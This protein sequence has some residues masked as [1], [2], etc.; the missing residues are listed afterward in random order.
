MRLDRCPQHASMA[1]AA[2]RCRRT[3]SAV[4]RPASTASRTR[5]CTNRYSPGPEV[6]STS[7][8]S[9]ASVQRGEALQ[10]RA[11]S[12][13][14]H[15]RHGELA[16]H[17]RRRPQQ[18]PRRRGSRPS[19]API[20]SRTLSVTGD[21]WPSAPVVASARRDL[22]DEERV[23]AGPGVHPLDDL[24][25]L[26]LPTDQ[27]RS[28]AGRHGRRGSPRISSATSRAPAADRRQDAGTRPVSRWLT[29]TSSRSTVIDR[30]TCWS[31]S[32]DACVGPLGV[33]EHDQQGTGQASP[34]AAAA[35]RRRT[36]GTGP[37]PD[38]SPPVGGIGPVNTSGAS[39]AR[40]P[41]S[42]A[43]AATAAQVDAARQ[44]AQDLAPRPVRRRPGRLGGRPPRR[45][46]PARRR[47][48]QA[49]RPA[50]SCRSRLARQRT[51][52]GRPACAERRQ[53]PSRRHSSPRPTISLRT[54]AP[55]WVR[56]GATGDVGTELAPV[57]IVPSPRRIVLA[58]PRPRPLPSHPPAWAAVELPARTQARSVR[59]SAD[60]R[61]VAVS[62]SLLR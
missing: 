53:S 8:A 31:S 29:T 37:P 26:D 51:T 22:A 23:P 52:R 50:G 58:L 56:M 34:R 13:R 57:Q 36:A 15:Q 27:R 18:P 14:R 38:Q 21:A 10:H 33:V 32:S 5:S 55:P 49:P 59:V 4:P 41:P 7:P 28:A 54:V 2:L 6:A 16:A 46:D 62:P 35:S 24:A 17:D 43:R 25:V 60:G 45:R 40:S 3:R 44:R 1:S 47:R 48:R 11:S 61:A 12:I 20:A 30:A 39:R 9:A 42:R 19:R